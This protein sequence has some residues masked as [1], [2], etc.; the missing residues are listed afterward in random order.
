[1]TTLDVPAVVDPSDAPRDDFVMR[2]DPAAIKHLGLQM[3]STL[4]PVIAELVANAW[5]A[6]ASNVHI[7][8][9][10]GHLNDESR[11]VVT[12]DGDGM[13][14]TDVREAYLIVGRDRR[15]DE[16]ADRRKTPPLRK[17]M[18][19]KGIGKFA[20]FG[21]ARQVEIESVKNGH[22]SRFL[23][24]YELME[25]A[26]ETREVRFPPLGPTG[27]VTK[28]TKVTLK[29]IGKF[30][31]RSIDIAGL[32]R[33]LARRFSVIDSNFTV[34]VNSVPITAAERD[35]TRLLEVDA[36]GERYLWT[37]E[38][39]EIAPGTGWRVSGWIGALDR[40]SKLEDGIQ[41]GIVVMARGKLVQEPFVFNATV[42]QQYALSYI[43]GELH[44]EFV[45]EAEDSVGTTR[46]SL[47]WDTEPN[48]AFHRW[49]E[50]EINTIAREWA[51]RRSRDNEKNLKQNESYRRFVDATKDMENQR[52]RKV[53]DKLIRD[54]VNRNVVAKPQETDE[55]VQLCIDFLEYD[56]FWDLAED[57]TEARV[58]DTGRLAQ[59]FREWEVVEAK[60]MARVTQGRITTIEKLQ[61]LIEDN[62]LEVPVLHDFLKQFPWVLDPR[63][64]L[65]ADELRYSK[66][67]RD[68][69]PEGTEVPEKDRRIDFLCVRESDTLVVVEIKRPHSV[70]SMNELGQIEQYVHFMRHHIRSAT[71]GDYS[72]KKVVGY[73]LCGRVANSYGPT[74]KVQSLHKDDIHVRFYSD[75]LGM[76]QRTHADF[77][78][79][80]NELR[81]L[82]EDRSN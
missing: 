25:K 59:L 37:Y 58:E 53:A 42:G 4:P 36:D 12:D 18:G 81:R 24:D 31:T 47:V 52:A 10:D 79:R 51:A 48:S 13:D 73:L 43:I 14:D 50:R 29:Q 39:I 30:R 61:K 45:D 49:G 33:G 2:F 8:V 23:M 5:D 27:T 32:R 71:D 65:V 9:P 80:Y 74:E 75:L 3:Y 28:G 16:K 78:Q 6:G 22:V 63:W 1:M 82:K 26:V 15:R 72:A 77:L 34:S 54:V 66:I 69:F 67:L 41:R 46:N 11:I 68:N 7:E 35:L 20:G 55:I 62:A 57:L 21:I 44:A 38:N 56:A 60:E 19:R 64:Q 17:V 40:T 70:V 76:V